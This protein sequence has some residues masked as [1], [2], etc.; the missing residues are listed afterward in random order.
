MTTIQDLAPYPRRAEDVT[1]KAIVKHYATF[2]LFHHRRSMELDINTDR[3][4]Y[5]RS[6]NMACLGYALTAVLR[7]TFEPFDAE[8]DVLAREFW[9]EF[10]DPSGFGPDLW[11]WCRELGVD[12]Q[13]V[14]DAADSSMRPPISA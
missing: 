5:D 7:S 1:A 11:R 10:G 4:A 8:S 14:V 12:P 9:T 13:A 6:V 3:A 2:T